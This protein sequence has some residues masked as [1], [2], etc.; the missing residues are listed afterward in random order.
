MSHTYDHPRPALTA[1]AVVFRLGTNGQAQVLLVKRKN[2][3]FHGQWALPGG[4]FDDE[5]FDIAVTA[6]RELFEE[7]GLLL[8]TLLRLSH[9]VSEAGR[10][11]RERVVSAIYVAILRDELADFEPKA[12][13]D[14]SEAA[15]VNVDDVEEMAF[16]HADIVFNLCSFFSSQ[17]FDK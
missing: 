4:F 12:G 6:Q 14:A 1:D 8:V 13:D 16:D 9:I 15:W 3:P 11:P 17:I 7:T 2:K 5:D 10:D